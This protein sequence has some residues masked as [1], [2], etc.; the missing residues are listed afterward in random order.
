MTVAEHSLNLITLIQFAN[1]V[2]A[3]L[4]G[5]AAGGGGGGGGAGTVH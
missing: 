5:S 1:N 3:F 2:R 4:I